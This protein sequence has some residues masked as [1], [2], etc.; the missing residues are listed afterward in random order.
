MMIPKAVA[1]AR[2]VAEV[3]HLEPRVKSQESRTKRGCIK[4][5]LSTQT[6]E[7]NLGIL[8]LS[9]NLVPL[10]LLVVNFY[11]YEH[12]GFHKVHEVL[13]QPLFCYDILYR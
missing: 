2:A 1:K 3:D 7:L 6:T 8:F 9:A 10:V 12:K 5:L 4:C 13:I 11:H